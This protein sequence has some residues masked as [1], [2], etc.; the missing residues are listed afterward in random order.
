MGEGGY[1]E[2]EMGAKERG[3]ANRGA[4]LDRGPTRFSCMTERGTKNMYMGAKE[5][6]RAKRGHREQVKGE[7]KVGQAPT[8]F[9]CMAEGAKE[10]GR[11]WGGGGG[12]NWTRFYKG[13]TL[14]NHIN[15]E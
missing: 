3:R 5:K 8:R 11:A 15:K 6:R 1:I 2:L 12:Q 14:C 7:G 10:K 13:K 4:K 9:F